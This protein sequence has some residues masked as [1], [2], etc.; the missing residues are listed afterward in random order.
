[1]ALT[2]RERTTSLYHFLIR[3]AGV[4]GGVWT[5]AAFGLRVVNRAQN[6]VTGN[7]DRV[8]GW[9]RPSLLPRASSGMGMAGGV[10]GGMGGGMA[11]GMVR[12]GTGEVVFDYKE[13]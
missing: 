12:R 8:A 1:M 13:K 4:V 11:Q 5:V 7:G 2:I 3:L 9:E 6:V 10:G